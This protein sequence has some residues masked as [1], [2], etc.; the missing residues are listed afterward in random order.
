MKDDPNDIRMREQ[1]KNLSVLSQKDI[2]IKKEYIDDS[3]HPYHDAIMKLKS[4][5]VVML[6]T[7]KLRAIILSSQAAMKRMVEICSNENV[8]AG[9]GMQACILLSDIFCG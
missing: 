7:Q 9:A 6:P 5:P 2:G 8:V 4:L 3:M 1:Y